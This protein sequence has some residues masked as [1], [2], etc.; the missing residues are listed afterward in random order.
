MIGETA[1]PADNDSVPYMEQLRFAERTLL[2]S[3]ACGAIGYSWWQFQDVEWNRFHPNYMGVLSREGI[4]RTRNGE[5]VRGSPK[6]V[7]QAFQ[8]F[9]PGHQ[10]NA[11]PSQLLELFRRA[12]M[13]DPDVWS[14]RM[15]PSMKA[16]CSLGTSRTSA[17]PPLVAPTAGP[18]CAALR[19]YH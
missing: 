19:L 8:R 18:N 4:S 5:E 10:G 16:R 15:E 1:I 3:R 14:I 12:Q 6:P 11:S 2:Q 9:D 7:V 17:I 13:Q